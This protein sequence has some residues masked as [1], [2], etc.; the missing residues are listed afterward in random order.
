ML[1]TTRIRREGFS[2]RPPFADFMQRFGIL[3]YGPTAQV[4][5][6]AETCRRVLEKSNVG[7]WLIGRTKVFLKYWQVEQ[8]DKSIKLF[9]DNAKTLQKLARGFR[10]RRCVLLCVVYPRCVLWKG[11]GGGAGHSIVF[12]SFPRLKKAN[13]CSFCLLSYFLSPLAPDLRLW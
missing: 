13:D 2:F 4:Q 8:L 9:H 11:G 5:P 6:S 12:Y 10:V 1:E 7:G 3:A